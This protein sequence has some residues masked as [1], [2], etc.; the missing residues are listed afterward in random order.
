MI[1]AVI[2]G[3][4]YLALKIPF[5]HFQSR[6]NLAKQVTVGINIPYPSEI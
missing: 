4:N 5:G 1:L 6:G 2:Y 3:V